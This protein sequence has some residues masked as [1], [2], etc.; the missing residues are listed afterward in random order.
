MCCVWQEKVTSK[1]G[2]VVSVVTSVAKEALD[3]VWDEVKDTR[4]G[5]MGLDFDIKTSKNLEGQQRVQPLPGVQ[6]TGVFPTFTFINTHFDIDASFFIEMEF[7]VLSRS[8]FNLLPGSDKNSKLSSF[9]GSNMVRTSM[10]MRA[11]QDV[12]LHTQI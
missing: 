11:N 1:F 3:T 2:S 5:D 8:A 6:G 7:N 12:S 4:Q 10:G 9:L